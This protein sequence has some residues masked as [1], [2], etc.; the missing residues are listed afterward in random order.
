VSEPSCFVFERFECGRV[1]G[2][3]LL[4]VWG[5]RVTGLGRKSAIMLLSQS[6]SYNEKQIS[7]IS[8][9]WRERG[10]ARERG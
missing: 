10:G 7:A 1:V 3:R 9:A 6:F 5:V 2:G 4:L 8:T